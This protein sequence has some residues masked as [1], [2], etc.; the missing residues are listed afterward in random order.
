MLCHNIHIIKTWILQTMQVTEFHKTHKRRY[1]YS[2]LGYTFQISFY[3][4]C[5]W[6]ALY[7]L[8]HPALEKLLTSNTQ[9]SLPC[10]PVLMLIVCLR[11]REGDMLWICA[12]VNP[13]STLCF[14]SN[15][16]VCRNS[17]SSESYEVIQA[18][19]HL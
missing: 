14:L 4:A 8:N 6:K 16:I 2:K 15:S 12:D 10:V 3:K 9:F 7:S 18:A 17:N 13:A 5:L 11:A 19:F 1:V